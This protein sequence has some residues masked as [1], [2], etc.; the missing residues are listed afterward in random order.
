MVQRGEPYELYEY[1]SSSTSESTIRLESVHAGNKFTTAVVVK[2][3]LFGQDKPE[4]CRPSH[5]YFR[6]R[7]GW[8]KYSFVHGSSLVT[9][10]LVH[11]AEC[12]TG[13]YQDNKISDTLTGL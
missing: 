11:I 6:R 10:V 13:I 7:P 4:R 12:A 5:V 8:K 2:G 3:K 9:R 1:T